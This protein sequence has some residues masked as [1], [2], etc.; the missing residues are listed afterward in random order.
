MEPFHYYDCEKT[1]KAHENQ[2]LQKKKKNPKS[3][4]KPQKNCTYLPEIMRKKLSRKP[5]NLKKAVPEMKRSNRALKSQEQSKD[6][7]S[8][9]THE[10][11]TETENDPDRRLLFP[12]EFW[13]FGSKYIKKGGQKDGKSFT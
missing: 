11:F 8:N 4:T 13:S 12:C 10:K 7:D 6:D 1:Q 3:T 5:F 2:K 9:Q